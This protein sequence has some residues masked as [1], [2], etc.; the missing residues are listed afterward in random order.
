MILILPLAASVIAYAVLILSIGLFIVALLWVIR[1]GGVSILTQLAPREQAF[2]KA[3]AL[4]N[5]GSWQDAF[6]AAGQLRNPAKPNPTFERRINT[7]EGECLY[8]AAE[9]AL[10]SH[11]YSEALELMRGAGDRLGLPEAEFDKRVV[12][13]LLAEIRRQV[14]LP[15]GGD[16]VAFLVQEIVRVTTGCPEA[17]FWLGLRHLIAGKFDDARTAL[18]AALGEPTVPDA[19]L[20]LGAL[21]RRTG[22]SREAARW[23]DHAVRQ[24]PDCPVVQWQYG[25][26]LLDTGGDPARAVRALE[27]ATGPKG[28]GKHL[29]APQKIWINTL[30]S[31]SWLAKVTG[32]TPLACP[33]G[34][35][36]PGVALAEARRLLGQALERC[37]RPSD[38]ATAFRQA[39]SAGDESLP[40][41]RGLGYNLAR[42]AM[43]DEALPHLQTV[44][45]R[46]QPVSPLT[47]GYLAL[48]TARA[49]AGTHQDRVAQLSAGLG[50]LTSLSVRGD[51]DWLNLSR[52]LLREAQT[53]G[54][55]ITPPQLAELA[56]VFASAGAYDLQAAELYN[57]F[58]ASGQ[59]IPAEVAWLYICAA[60]ELG[61]RLSHDDAL[62]DRAFRDR[63]GA[64]R[65]FMEK[66]REFAPIERV[67]LERWAQHHDGR[68]PE[69]PGSLYP[70][71]AERVLVEESRRHELNGR[72]DA[73]LAAARL[74][75][76]MGPNRALTLDRLAELAY[77]RGDRPA[78]EH[79][80]STWIENHP[81][82][83]RPL[84]RRGVLARLDGRAGDALRLIT[85]A[86]DKATG[87]T[88]TKYLVLGA[89]IAVAANEPQKAAELLDRA[90]T[91]GPLDPESLTA[92]AALW[93]QHGEFDKL[94][95]LNEELEAN[96]GNDAFRGLLAGLCHHL[97][98]DEA[99]AEVAL[100]RPS[101][102]EHLKPEA[103]LLQ[104]IVLGWQNRDDDAR[105]VLAELEP[106]GATRDLVFGMRGQL[107]WKAGDYADALAAWQQVP[108]AKREVWKLTPLMSAGA[109][110]AGV[111]SLSADQPA[112][113]LAAFRRATSAGF[114]DPRL[115]SMEVRAVQR[116]I[117]AGPAG[118]GAVTA[119]QLRGLE[120]TLTA[121][122]PTPAAAAWLARGYRR[123]GHPG[124]ARRLLEGVTGEDHH[125]LLQKGLLHLHER[126]LAAAE[127]EFVA[128]LEKAP[129]SPAAMTNLCLIR[130][131]IGRFEELP[132][133]LDRAA[134]RAGFAELKRTL[135]MYKSLLP[136]QEIDPVLLELN[137][138]D[139]MR[140]LWRLQ[141]LGRLE[142]TA[143]MVER[144]AEARPDSTPVQQAKAEVQ[145]LWTKHLIDR[146]DAAEALKI[147]P[148]VA[149]AGSRALRNLLGVAAC[150]LQ[151]FGKAIKFFQSSL[152]PQGDDARVQQNLALASIW[153]GDRERAAAHWK[154]CLA[155]LAS[156]CPAPPGDADYLLRL[157]RAV[158]RRQ[159]ADEAGTP[160]P[161]EVAT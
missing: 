25:A 98:G 54:V 27:I 77:R 116:V 32:R 15:T 142:T 16:D 56:N 51:A 33:L 112:E 91:A 64:K 5:Q 28:L 144:L 138:P 63:E 90:R 43:Y 87:P 149:A 73:A 158:R 121:T 4:L 26:A 10:S 30:P 13:V 36:Q 65:Y 103:G 35:D 23:L 29:E 9:E 143:P 92:L 55:T 44:R 20:Y 96:R 97:T 111:K 6:A 152:P 40:V 22:R 99:R 74:A 93:W 107:A 150:L 39:L 134:E 79:Y 105:T 49:K 95:Q 130:L 132:E 108:A 83:P 135:R 70:A 127:A 156:H 128:A 139:E 123:Q 34:L 57:T 119:E 52:E 62:F 48:C 94:A 146:G 58:A 78:T 37:E 84:V 24:A 82:D 100:R 1:P 141:R 109:F 114:N 151:Q 8:R 161:E 117:Q 67:Y 154:R 101:E 18:H 140:L 12:D 110:L 3:Q 86:C 133:L 59:T 76:K 131:S 17:S 53:A 89:R 155:H 2:R 11:R 46:E 102:D 104:A 148:Q 88:K 14:V 41:L 136:G 60:A 50:V 113:A 71:I 80:L 66:Q 75:E 106:N 85:E 81:N 129:D 72:P 47:I 38:A 137:P 31:H 153:K 122:S 61:L 115:A 160:L 120:N 45:T 7:F 147:D 159:E 124:E 125:I 126:Q 145:V 69:A 19:A 21:D 68:Y 157:G 42:A 118:S